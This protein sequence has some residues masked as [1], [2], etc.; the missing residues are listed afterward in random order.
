MVPAF[1]GNNMTINIDLK[2]SQDAGK[3]QSVEIKL[4]VDVFQ[5]VLFEISTT[6]L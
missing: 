2:L 6:N 4:Y 1:S 3:Q 5:I